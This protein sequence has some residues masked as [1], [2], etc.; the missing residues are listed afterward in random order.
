MSRFFDPAALGRPAV[1]IACG[2]HAVSFVRRKPGIVDYVEI[3]FEQLRHDATA[4][5]LQDHVPLLL[6]CASLSVC[7][8]VPPDAPTLDAI[9]EWTQRTRSPWIGEHL[10]FVRAEHIEPGDSSEPNILTFT[11]C[12]QFSERVLERTVD[13]LN[14]LRQRLGV[15]IVLENPPQYFVVPGSTMGQVDFIRALAERSDIGLIC[16]L[17]HFLIT[18]T[19]MG[20]DAQ[21]ELERLPLELTVE[22]HLSGIKRRNGLAWDDH[23]SGTPREAFELLRQVRRRVAPRAVTLEYNS[24]P[25]FD[26]DVL[27]RHVGQVREILDCAP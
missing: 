15:P 18:A 7:G 8:F 1:G 26:D 24:A 12:P 3:P 11:V 20:L 22:V 21:T 2:P 10:A 19:N 5:C 6:H 13:N 23:T 27:V 9:A 14:A 16:D 4:A 25:D 17:T